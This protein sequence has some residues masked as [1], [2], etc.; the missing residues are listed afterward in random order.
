L[1]DFMDNEKVVSVFIDMCRRIHALGFVSGPG[2]NISMRCD[3]AI[4]ITP[5]GYSLGSIHKND[6]IYLSMDGRWHSG[7]DVKPSKEWR[8]HLGCYQRE[9]VNAVVHVH[10]VYAVA[11]S[12]LKN[13]N[14]AC[15]LPIYTP[16]YGTRV[17]KLPMLP[18]MLPGSEALAQQ[19]IP[20][21]QVRNSVLMANHGTLAVGSTLET[22][23]NLVDEIEENAKLR[24]IL[25]DEGVALSEEE[26]AVLTPMGMRK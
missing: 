20:V 16:G 5:S 25:G 6:V 14:P 1:V 7:A 19:V 17:G 26:Q 11:A 12:C 8:M 21:I 4:M 3:D 24:F 22:A 15:A 23:F 18:Y 13:A 2:G 10:S 9:D